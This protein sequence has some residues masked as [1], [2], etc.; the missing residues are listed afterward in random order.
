MSDDRVNDLLTRFM[1]RLN[2]QIGA[3]HERVREDNARKRR[4]FR[5]SP[6]LGIASNI[7][8]GPM[9]L[10]PETDEEFLAYASRRV[11]TILDDPLCVRYNNYL[12]GRNGHHPNT[13]WWHALGHQMLVEA[14]WSNAITRAQMTPEVIRD[15]AQ[16]DS[17]ITVW[18]PRLFP[19]DGEPLLLSPTEAA[20]EWMGRTRTAQTYLWHQNTLEAACAAPLPEHVF[21]PNALPFTSLFFSFEM[22][23]W[24]TRESDMLAQETGEKIP[25]HTETWWC[26]ITRLGDAGAM[27]TFDR[28]TWP[29]DERLLGM[30]YLVMEPLPWG[31][32]W[33]Q[34][35]EGRLHF[36]QIGAVLR[37]LAFMQAPFV[38]TI[39]MTRSLPRPIR[40]DYDRV[41]KKWP[42]QQVSI[43]T[44]RARPQEPTYR[45]GDVEGALRQY[46]H[47]WWVNGHYRWQYY[48]ST[49]EHKLIAIAPFM[50]QIGKP[51]LR[52]LRDVSR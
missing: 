9:G 22:A 29:D 35:F 8:Q 38:D 32:R 17:M 49:R 4:L 10:E 44:L 48:P 30:Q 46:Q 43:I 27:L 28:Q 25:G 19:D 26:L 52:Q 42:T 7:I 20:F 11:R 39:P 16:H 50:K 5:Q 34:D 13:E 24:T 21:Q 47:S 51:L 6:A 18:D 33:P 37:M 31:A 45:D 36:N 3:D 1:E 41:N 40:R 15:H 23:A 12:S 14:V 2:E